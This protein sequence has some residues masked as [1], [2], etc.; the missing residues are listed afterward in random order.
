MKFTII[1]ALGDEF[2]VLAAL[3]DASAVYHDYF[4]GVLDGGEPVGY[5]D[6][7]AVVHKVVQSVLHG[8]FA[9]GVERCGRLVQNEDGPLPGFT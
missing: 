5:G 8:P 1:T 9:L 6:G 2:V 7:G 4:V 3:H